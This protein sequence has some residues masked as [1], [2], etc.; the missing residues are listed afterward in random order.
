MNY[1]CASIN[2]KDEWNISDF[3]IGKKDSF[4]THTN[5]ILGDIIVL[6]V[7]KQDPKVLSGTYAKALF[8]RKSEN[9][10]LYL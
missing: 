5:M 9:D 8:L 3:S 7:G 1:F 10:T 4:Y 2:P 6:V